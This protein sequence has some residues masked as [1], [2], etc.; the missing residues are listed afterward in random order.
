LRIRTE[1]FMGDQS[2]Q[3]QPHPITKHSIYAPLPLSLSPPGVRRMVY[4]RAVR[5]TESQLRRWLTS[6]SC[7]CFVSMD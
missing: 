4:C 1:I 6:L 5:L 3:A 7:R 2:M